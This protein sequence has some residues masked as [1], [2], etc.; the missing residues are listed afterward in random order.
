MEQRDIERQSAGA[1]QARHVGEKHR[2]ICRRPGRDRITRARIDEQSA[3]T[4]VRSR[5]GSRLGH[6]TVDVEMDQLH[7]MKFR[8]AVQ[9][10]AEER[11]RDSA[12]G[13]E[14]DTVSALDQPDG[15]PGRGCLLGREK[16][17]R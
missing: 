4:D 6:V 12:A 10:G 1:E 5:S 15:F 8:T 14:I 11:A 7:V 3:T 9:E 2:Q 13:V 17:H 16:V